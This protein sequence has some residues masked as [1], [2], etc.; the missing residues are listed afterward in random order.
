VGICIAVAAILRNA[1]TS[2]AGDIG[3]DINSQ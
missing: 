1:L 3:S 2:K